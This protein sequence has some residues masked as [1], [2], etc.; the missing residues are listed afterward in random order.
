MCTTGISFGYLPFLFHTIFSYY[1]ELLFLCSS[2]HATLLF[3]C[4]LYFFFPFLPTIVSLLSSLYDCPIATTLKSWRN[5]GRTRMMGVYSIVCVALLAVATLGVEVPDAPSTVEVFRYSD[6]QLRVQLTE[7]LSDNG[8]EVT[9]CAV[10][11]DTEPGV[12]EVQS[13]TTTLNLGPN[14]IQTVSSSADNI[15]EVKIIHTQATEVDEVQTITTYANPGETLSGTFTVTFDTSADGG[16]VETSSP[17]SFDADPDSA[18]M[19]SV[20]SVL[21]AMKNIDTV[22]V[23]RAVYGADENIFDAF[24][25][26]ITFTGASNEGNIPQ[27]RLATSNLVATGI[28]DRIRPSAPRCISALHMQDVR[29]FMSTAPLCLFRSWRCI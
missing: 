5:P 8:A 9:S 12:R 17:I 7:P 1:F 2:V 28:Y 10:E 25:W 20:K 4:L 27:L 18:S 6:T 26:S 24:V 21:E 23:T 22:N 16:S 19:T 15:P 13:I 29:P 14:E 3:S 11:W